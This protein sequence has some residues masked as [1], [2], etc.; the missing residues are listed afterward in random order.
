MLTSTFDLKLYILKKKNHVEKKIVFFTVMLQCLFKSTLETFS[1]HKKTL[2]TSVFI[3]YEGAGRSGLPT[4]R[5]P[6]PG[7]I[8]H[9]IFMFFIEK[10]TAFTL[11]FS[12]LY[13]CY[14]GIFLRGLFFQPKIPIRYPRHFLILPIKN[15]ILNVFFFL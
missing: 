4:V 9:R 14:I 1:L 5:F 12:F 3:F 10:N 7:F 2:F 11:S 13:I 15:N 8:S 6:F